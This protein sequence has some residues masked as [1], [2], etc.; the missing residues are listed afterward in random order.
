M[1]LKLQSFSNSDFGHELY[2]E[3]SEAISFSLKPL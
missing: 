2:F 3:I 1:I